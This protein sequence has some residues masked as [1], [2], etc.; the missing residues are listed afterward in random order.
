MHFDAHLILHIT[1][2]VVRGIRFYIITLKQ[3]GA[4]F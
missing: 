4:Q 2:V 1:G 3:Y